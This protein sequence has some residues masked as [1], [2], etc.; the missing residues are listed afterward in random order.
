MLARKIRCLGSLSNLLPCVLLMA[1]GAVVQLLS[2]S[3]IAVPAAHAQAVAPRITVLSNPPGA[4]VFVDGALQ[5]QTGPNFK[6]RMNKGQHRLRLELEGHKPFEQMVAISAAQTFTFNLEKAPAR[7]DIKYPGTNDAARG[8]DILVDGTPAGSV[9]QLVDLPAGRHLIEIRKP[10]HKVYSEN[11]EVKAGETRPIWVTLTAEARHGSLVIA[12]D[13]PAEVFVDG[14]P[15]G[16]APAVAEGLNEG[17]HVVEVRRNEAGAP[18]WRQTVRVT[19]NQQVKLM[20]QTLPP[21]PSPGTLMVLTTPTDADVTV[22]NE[23]KGKG[24]QPITLAAGPHAIKVSSKGYQDVVREV[25]IEPGKPRI[26]KVELTGSAESR[27]KGFVRI[28]MTTPLDGAQYFVNGRQ[29]DES[30]ALSDQGVEVAAGR[31]L[32]AVKKDGY[33]SAK[34]EVQLRPGGTEVVEIELKNVGKLYIASQPPGAFVLL[35]RDLIGQTPITRENVPAGPHAIEI[36]KEKYE[37]HREQATVRAGEQENVSVILRPMA[38]PPVDKIAI[39]RALNSFSAVTNEAGHFTTDVGVGYPYFANLRINVGMFKKK[40]VK[41]VGA[42]GL[43]G[44]A[45]F[46]TTLYSFE[47]GGNIRLQALHRGPFALGLNTYLGGGGGPRG[48][49]TFQWELG[50]PIT[51]LAGSI[52]K[53]TARPYVQVYTDRNCPS[54]ESLMELRMKNDITAIERLGDAINQAEHNGDRCVGRTYDTMGA[55]NPT[56]GD[57]ANPIYDAAGYNPG[58][59][60]F[61]RMPTYNAGSLLYQEDGI[62]VLERFTQARFMLQAVVELAISP[63]LNIWGLLEGAP[64]QKDRQMFTDKF[65]RVFP[66]NETPIYGRAGMTLK[67]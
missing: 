5:G 14:Q 2:P 4:N 64:G 35:D 55:R 1:L 18:V 45:E 39:Q 42:V 27:G 50:L 41:G 6:V 60:K 22:D 16:P 40:D 49:N 13:A 12:A 63:N 9:P 58:T 21:P 3:L 25:N 19:A 67:F 54:Q 44:G 56:T 31:V 26:E 30:A 47:V 32:V 28:I 11:V 10:G 33:G 17:E 24:G 62:G 51:L 23:P 20:A 37:T 43:D 48:R 15:K 34:R 53:L 61:D 66:I 57:F 59:R 52:V 65:N 7:L 29:I 38:A 8:A 46:R 36:Q